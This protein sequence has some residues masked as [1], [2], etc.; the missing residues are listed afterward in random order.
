LSGTAWGRAS[1]AE[2]GK[3]GIILT[4]KGGRRTKGKRK[5]PSFETTKGRPGKVVDGAHWGEIARIEG[6]ERHLRTSSLLA[7]LLGS[8]L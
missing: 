8:H 6:D 1:A 7:E 2:E 3:V 4:R 5:K